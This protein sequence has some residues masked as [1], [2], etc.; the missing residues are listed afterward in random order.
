[1][2][3][4][5]YKTETLISAHKDSKEEAIRLWACIAQCESNEE[6]PNYMQMLVSIFGEDVYS[7]S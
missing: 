3:N 2:E 4:K 7:K 1:M 6:V 5:N